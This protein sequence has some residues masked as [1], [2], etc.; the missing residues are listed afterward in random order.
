MVKSGAGYRER[1]GDRSQR[2]PK[3]AKHRVLP[4]PCVAARFA[5][6]GRAR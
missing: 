1:S 5:A 3:A 2:E 4:L 6:I